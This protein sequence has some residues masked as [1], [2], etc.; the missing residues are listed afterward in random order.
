MFDHGLADCRSNSDFSLAGH[1]LVHLAPGGENS[2]DVSG[3]SLNLCK[4]VYLEPTVA[5]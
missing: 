3:I 5:S 2:Q 1:N 4:F